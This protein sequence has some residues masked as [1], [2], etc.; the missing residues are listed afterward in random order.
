M[1]HIVLL[2]CSLDLAARARSPAIT[3]GYQPRHFERSFHFAQ[4]LQTTGLKGVQSPLV[5]KRQDV[6]S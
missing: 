6:V 2:Y 5:V 3:L 1:P 4:R